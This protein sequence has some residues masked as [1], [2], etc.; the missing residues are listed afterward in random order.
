MTQSTEINQQAAPLAPTN[1]PY[2]LIVTTN[3]EQVKRIAK[4]FDLSDVR[5]VDDLDLPS[6]GA[7]RGDALQHLLG[8][9]ENTITLALITDDP[10]VSALISNMPGMSASVWRSI[11]SQLLGH[12]TGGQ[13]NFMIFANTFNTG[14]R[15]AEDNGKLMAIVAGQPLPHN[16]KPAPAPKAEAKP[17][18]AKPQVE[19][20]AQPQKP[21]KVKNATRTGVVGNPEGFKG[22]GKKVD[23]QQVDRSK[24]MKGPKPAGNNN[25]LYDDLYLLA[26][27]HYGPIGRVA[28]L[29]KAGAIIAHHTGSPIENVHC[30]KI[31]LSLFNT[32][33]AKSNRGYWGGFNLL[34]EVVVAGSDS[35]MELINTLSGW[36]GTIPVTD[37]KGETIPQPQCNAA[38]TKLFKVE[39]VQPVVGQTQVASNDHVAPV[40]HRGAAT[41]L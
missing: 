11:E 40:E 27:G 36:I 19:K 18:Q 10:W 6:G 13:R 38:V 31:V 30:E 35:A 24:K 41:A 33:I 9:T 37:A 17:V 7:K 8:Q 25:G 15:E 5:F 16:W 3:R 12:R 20:K 39:T 14:V 2:N 23:K 22:Q 1:V 28:F 4:H 21:Q 29:S 26:K 32:L 34:K